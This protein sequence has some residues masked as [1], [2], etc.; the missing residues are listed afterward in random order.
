MPG[1]GETHTNLNPLVVG[2]SPTRPTIHKRGS[3]CRVATQGKNFSVLAEISYTNSLRMAYT[4][5]S[6]LF[7]SFSF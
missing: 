7:D 3:S 1:S 5:N 2:S 4:V 6:A